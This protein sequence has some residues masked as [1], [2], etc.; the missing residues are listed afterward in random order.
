[1]RQKCINCEYCD[2][3][4]WENEIENTSG[5]ML[6]CRICMGPIPK[7]ILYRYNPCS[8]YKNKEEKK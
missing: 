1:M 5:T 8:W 7:K 3:V 4:T 2:E 6:C